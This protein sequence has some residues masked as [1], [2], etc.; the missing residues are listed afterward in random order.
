MSDSRL[1]G[2]FL[3]LLGALCFSTTGTMQAIAPEEASPLTITFARMS[4]GFLSLFLWCLIRRKFPSD[5]KHLP[6]KRLAICALCIFGFQAFFFSSVQFVGVAI[7]TVI[8]IGVTPCAAAVI[9]FLLYS[10]VPAKP[11][12]VA[13]PL[14]IL[15]VVLMN[16]VSMGEASGW[17][18]IFPILA[19]CCYACYITVS[20][21]LLE[22]ISPEANMAIIMGMISVAMLPVLFFYPI[23]WMATPWGLFVSLELGIVTAGCAFSFFLAGLRQTES[24][25]A[26]TLSLGEPLGAVC[27]GIFLL[28]EELS[29]KA[30]LGIGLVFLSILVL[31]FFES[32]GKNRVNEPEE[33]VQEA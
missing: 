32:K 5:F 25:V 22:K 4:L 17:Q 21:P 11:W 27:W 30:A 12:F 2:P 20:P 14:A 24:T 19:G 13:T 16:D 28:N 7:G 31:C 1:F 23:R 26:S 6:W 15:G 29:V 10:R 8:S 9:A 18:T 3:V 33:K